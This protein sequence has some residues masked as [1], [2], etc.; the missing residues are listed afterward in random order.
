MLPATHGLLAD[1]ASALDVASAMDRLRI[2]CNAVDTKFR[3]KVLGFFKGATKALQHPERQQPPKLPNR[4]KYLNR[5]DEDSSLRAGR[6]RT[7]DAM[8]AVLYLGWPK[9]PPQSGASRQ[10]QHRRRQKDRQRQEL[11]RQRGLH[12]ALQAEHGTACDALAAAALAVA[13]AA[14]ATTSGR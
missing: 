8:D 9:Q 14:L 13:A 1:V 7:Y 2:E 12:A 6:K 5:L 10:Q 3:P 11:E 4:N